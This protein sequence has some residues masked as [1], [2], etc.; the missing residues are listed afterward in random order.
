MVQIQAKSFYRLSV[1]YSMVS[2]F[3][4]EPLVF[5]I[6][7]DSGNVYLLKELNY[8]RDR[9]RYSMIVTVHEQNTN[10]KSEA[11]VPISLFTNVK[12]QT[13]L[14]L[15]FSLGFHVHASKCAGERTTHWLW[16]PWGWSHEVQNRGSQWPHKM[17]LGPT[18]I[19]LKGF[20][21]WYRMCFATE[22]NWIQLSTSLCL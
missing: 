3:E 20:S 7:R 11:K 2:E 22:C 13:R 8:I 5:R 4:E 14:R 18:K 9:R 16:N 10:K 17:D 21:I 6:D 15:S 1:T 12:I 19:F